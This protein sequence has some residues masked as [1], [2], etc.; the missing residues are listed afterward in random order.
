[1]FATLFYLFFNEFLLK[2]PLWHKMSCAN[3]AAGIF[4]RMWLWESRATGSG[5]PHGTPPPT[6]EPIST[7]RFPELMSIN[8]NIMSL[9]R[10]E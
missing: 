10:S 2:L 1:M 4:P 7:F 9:E 6:T 5:A 8:V 3:Q